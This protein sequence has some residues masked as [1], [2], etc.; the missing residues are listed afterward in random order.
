MAQNDLESNGIYSRQ[1]G[2]MKAVNKLC[3]KRRPERERTGLHEVEADVRQY[4]H[5]QAGSQMTSRC[6]IFL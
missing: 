4:S 6:R 2:N 1:S 5:W 3:S